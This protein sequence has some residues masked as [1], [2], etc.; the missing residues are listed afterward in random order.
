MR[1]TNGSGTTGLGNER[2][3]RE[4]PELVESGYAGWAMKAKVSK[5]KNVNASKGGL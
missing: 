2:E 3:E 4:E 5:K 1:M